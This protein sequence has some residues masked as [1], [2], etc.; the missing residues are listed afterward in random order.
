MSTAGQS[1][2]D[3]FNAETGTDITTRGWV[4]TRRDAK[5]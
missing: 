3:I 4:K 2:R 5:A 1:I